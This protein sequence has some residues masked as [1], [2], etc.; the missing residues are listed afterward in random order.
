MLEFLYHLLCCPLGKDDDLYRVNPDQPKRV[1]SFISTFM[2]PAPVGLI[3][4]TD[5]LAPR[6]GQNLCQVQLAGLL[7]L[8]LRV[9]ALAGRHHL[10]QRV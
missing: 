9:C 6:C 1:W 7:E 10:L 8:A 4:S 3:S 5:Q 2:K